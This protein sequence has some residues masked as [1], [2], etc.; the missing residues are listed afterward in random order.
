[1]GTIKNTM[2]HKIR[3]SGARTI[4]AII[5]PASVHIGVLPTRAFEVPNLST[6]KRQGISE[7]VSGAFGIFSWASA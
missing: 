4:T 1:M 2:S 3:G 6:D 7:T 5:P